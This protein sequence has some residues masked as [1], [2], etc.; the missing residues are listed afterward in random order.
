MSDNTRAKY[1]I[2]LRDGSLVYRSEATDELTA[3]Y[4]WIPNDVANAIFKGTIKG[5]DVV[6]G[7]G[8]KILASPDFDW[9]KYQ[10][11]IRKLNMRQQKIEISEER[12][13]NLPPDNPKDSISLEE[14]GVPSPDAPAPAGQDTP[15]PAGQDTPAPTGQDA[16]APA[17]GGSNRSGG[18]GSRGGGR[19]SRNN[20]PAPAA[21]APAPAA[22]APAPAEPAP[23]EPAPAPAAEAPAA[24]TPA[25]DAPAPAAQDGDT[26]AESI[27]A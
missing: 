16:P 13:N 20:A 12:A 18:R 8:K 9:N 19:G 5:M 3:L 22:P 23:A 7:I 25:A 24:E 27:D 2:N 26:G 6:N 11:D 1:A 4:R 21:D 14:L 10:E 17:A 15:A